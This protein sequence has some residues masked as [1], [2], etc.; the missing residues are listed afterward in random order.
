MNTNKEFDVIE[1]LL[2]HKRLEPLEQVHIDELIRIQS[3]DVTTFTEADVREEIINPILRILGYRKGVFSSVDREK[4]ISFLGKT[5]RYIDY[6]LTLWEENFWL[7]EAKKPLSKG[8][9][10]D[11]LRQA[12]EYAIHPKINAALI[13]LCDGI[14]LEIFDREENLES[15]I[16]F[17]KISDL[18]V[19]FDNIRAILSPMQVWFFYKRR[20]L[21][22]IDKA[23]DSEFNQ[24]RVNEF[25]S[26]IENRFSQKRRKVLE[27]FQ[28]KNILYKDNQEHFKT[29]SL[30]NIVDIHFFFNHSITD[31]KIITKSLVNFCK[32]RGDFHIIDKIFPDYIRD[33][34]DHFY[35]NA[36]YFLIGLNQEN[37]SLN[38]CP[39]WLTSNED[40]SLEAAIKNLIALCLNYFSHDEPRKTILLASATFR[41]I[42]KLLGL[43]QNK[44]Q[45]AKYLHFINRYESP[46]I[47]WEQITASPEKNML[48]ILDRDTLITTEKFVRV[49]SDSDNNKFKVNLAK[50]QLRELWL[51]EKT[52]LESIQN[53]KQLRSERYLDQ[54][55][56]PT[57]ASCVVYDN[58]GHGCLCV[59]ENFPKWKEYILS[60]HA[61]EILQLA[62]IGSWAAKELIDKNNLSITDFEPINL[63]DYFF[64]GDEDIFNS[65]KK[66][67]GW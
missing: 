66:H 45:E 34:N 49:H 36:L 5:S 41:R 11:E 40:K 27:N 6:N 32:I 55:I 23:F 43:V 16:L 13:V 47:S 56:Y 50:Q 62:H 59:L 38:Y 26:L 4:H 1:H 17:I 29:E 10:Y 19:E 37:Y 22:A 57:E 2:T 12:I 35:M 64:F 7:I 33:A 28:N 44:F 14:K 61:K 25:K 8:F 46:E 53:Y 67:Y 9:G 21:K 31:T 65:L 63:A 15:P 24:K 58:L 3:L 60:K 39:N 54:E 30:D 52:I 18:V 20:V 51:F 48:L 42:I